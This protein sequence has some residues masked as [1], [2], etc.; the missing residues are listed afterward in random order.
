MKTHDQTVAGCIVSKGNKD[1][2]PTPG[3]RFG[4]FAQNISHVTVRD[5]ASEEDI[6]AVKRMLEDR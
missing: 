2:R 1:G 4:K 3:H 5:T 6:E